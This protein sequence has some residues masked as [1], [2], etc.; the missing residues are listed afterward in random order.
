MLDNITKE[1]PRLSNTSCIHIALLGTGYLQ[2]YH[3]DS[4]Q[5][6]CNKISPQISNPEAI[7]L[8]DIERILHALTMFDFD[9][10]TTPDIFNACFDEIHKTSRLAEKIKY[11]RTLVCTLYFLSIKNLYSYELMDR[12]LHEEYIA[13][14]YGK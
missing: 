10:H 4:L 2:S 8:K 14:N 12:V 6:V 13:I 9:P 11:V 3:T 7:R 5:K 1:I